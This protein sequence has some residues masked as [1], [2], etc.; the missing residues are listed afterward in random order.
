M[1][2]ASFNWGLLHWSVLLPWLLA[3]A[4]GIFVGATPGLTATMAVALIVPITFYIPDPNTSLAMILGVSFTA[5][6]AG[7][8]PA[9]YLR[10][11]GT[12]A[13]AAATLDSHQFAKQGRGREV[14]L[15]DLICSC[16]GGLFSVQALIW[17]APQLARWGLKFSNYEYFWLA[18]LGLSMS[19]VVS[20]GAVSKGLIAAAIGLLLATVG[21]DTVSG[22]QRF[23]FGNEELMDGINFIPVMIGLFGLSEVLRNIVQ[24]QT[25]E[26]AAKVVEQIPS[27]VKLWLTVW[28]HKFLV[29]RSSVLGTLVGALPGA[30]ADIAAWAAYGLAQRTS[31]E[32]EKF[33][34]GA[35]EG[36]IAPTSANNAAVGGAWIPALVFG[37]PGDA[38]TA[39]VLGA[40]IMYD[41]KPGPLI[42]QESPQKMHDL[43]SIALI[44]Q[45]LLLICGWIGIRAFGAIIKLPRPIIMAAVVVF[46]VV[47]AYAV[48]NS[49]FDVWLMLIF[50]IVGLLFER[51]AVPLPPLILGL[52]LGPMLEENLRTGLIKSSG[53]W[54]PFFVRPVCVTLIAILALGAIAPWLLNRIFSSRPPAKAP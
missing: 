32:G 41:I 18:I 19:A 14:V 52:I 42:F 10:I 24:P 49:V 26:K 6:F 46:S 2:D 3:M 31:K 12:P 4:F 33:G 45:F 43:F 27:A 40:M 1:G 48:R 36:V 15:L 37:I 25:F 53:D 7:D 22:Q 20:I 47:G 39:I 5:I 28:K 35:M 16:L 30:G 51:M 50:A 44:T 29:L 54:T 38:V 23:T 8:L 13:S 21:I 9:T 11:P 34:K 17:I